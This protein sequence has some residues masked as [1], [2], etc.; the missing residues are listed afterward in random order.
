MGPHLV[1]PLGS[2]NDIVSGPPANDGVSAMLTACVCTLGLHTS[3]LKFRTGYLISGINM[4]LCWVHVD[5]CV[6]MLGL[7]VFMLEPIST[8]DRTEQLAYMGTRGYILAVGISSVWSGQELSKPGTDVIQGWASLGPICFCANSARP[9]I[10]LFVDAGLL[11][12]G[13]N[14]KW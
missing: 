3:L 11:A 9:S 10:L 6:P 13:M 4:D 5:L 8:K 12:S 1:N 7:F 14:P 2:F